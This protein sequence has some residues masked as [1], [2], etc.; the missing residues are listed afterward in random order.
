MI[1]LVAE[2]QVTN[3]F[4]HSILAFDWQRASIIYQHERQFLKINSFDTIHRLTF[5]RTYSKSIIEHCFDCQTI[6]PWEIIFAYP[7]DSLNVNISFTDGQPFYFHCL[8]SILFTN[9]MRKKIIGCSNVFK[10]SSTGE[11]FLFLLIRKY[12][13]NGDEIYLKLFTNIISEYPVTISLRNEYEQTIFELIYFQQTKD[14]F[15][16]LRPFIQV[17]KTILI[18]QLT[19]NSAIEKLI[20]NYFGYFLLFIFKNQTLTMTKYVHHLLNSLKTNQDLIK[21]IQLLKQTIIDNDLTK[22]KSLFPYKS[23]IHN[24]KDSFGRTCAHLVVLYRRYEFFRY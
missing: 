3:E 4:L 14:N 20:F 11:T 7:I 23:N 8:N 10:K 6:E 13:E 22:F 17:M 21:S 9:E 18:K 24:A 2:H 16:K 1:H 19:N 12:I 15:L 5:I